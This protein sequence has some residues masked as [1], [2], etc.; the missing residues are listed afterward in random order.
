VHRLPPYAPSDRA[1]TDLPAT[2]QL[3]AAGMNLPT[4][5]Q[6]TEDDVARVADAIRSARR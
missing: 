6:M 5:T 3:A 1:P 4:A 2:D